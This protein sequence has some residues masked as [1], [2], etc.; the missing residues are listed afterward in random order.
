VS[1]P[2]NVVQVMNIEDP[3]PTLTRRG[4]QPWVRD[5]NEHRING[6]QTESKDTCL[7][8]SSNV[9]VSEIYAFKVF[10]LVCVWY[11]LAYLQ[12][13]YDSQGDK[14]IIDKKPF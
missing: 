12:M 7:T 6:K 8:L 11:N 13:R 4:H 14:V 5:F 9:L 3:K 10:P 2:S 1:E